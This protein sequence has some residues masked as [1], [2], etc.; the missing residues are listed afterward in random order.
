MCYHGYRYE[1]FRD[2]GLTDEELCYTQ[3]IV[4]LKD[5]T[6]TWRDVEWLTTFTRL[7]VIVK[8]ILTGKVFK[9]S[10]GPILYTHNDN[11][12]R[13]TCWVFLLLENSL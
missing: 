12:K 11:F 9:Y 8:G 1:N 2:A 10:S 4:N 6:W 5:N 3:P 7:P 13:G